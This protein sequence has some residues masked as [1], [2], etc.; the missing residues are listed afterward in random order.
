MKKKIIYLALMVTVLV[1]GACGAKDTVQ[2]KDLID[3]R[4]HPHKKTNLTFTFT[5]D[6]KVNVEGEYA[7]IK[8]DSTPEDI[9]S[10]EDEALIADGEY[11]DVKIT[12]KG[13]EYYVKG[14]GIDLT[15]KKTGDKEITDSKSD[16][17]LLDR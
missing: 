15:F 2:P 14:K 13:D 5:G 10:M 6:N 16:I 7:K 1:L 8:P 11:Q 9:E 17:Y 3:H 4:L 12:T